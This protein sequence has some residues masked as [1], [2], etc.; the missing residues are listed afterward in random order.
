MRRDKTTQEFVLER[1][2]VLKVTDT[3]ALKGAAILSITLH[4]Y[5]HRLLTNV[6]ENQFSFGPQRV[7]EFTSAVID[8][9][10][11]LQ[12]LLTFLGHFGVQIFIFLSAY[13]LTRKHGSKPPPW[14]EFVWQR[15]RKLYPMVLALAVGWVLLAGLP[16]GITG[17]QRV[18]ENHGTSLLLTILGVSNMVPGYASPAIGPWWFIPF[19]MQ[20][21]CIWPALVRFDNRFGP[22]GL[23]LLAGACVGITYFV[24]GMLAPYHLTALRWPLGHMPEICLGI[25]AARYGFYP[26]MTGG[27][28]A[29]VVFV[30]SNFYA[31]LWL[32]SFPAALVICLSLYAAGQRRISSS[33]FL[34]YVGALAMPLFLINTI[35]RRYVLM[36]ASRDDTWIAG[37]ILGFVS[38]GASI[39]AA[40]LL[41]RA[42]AVAGARQD[43]Y[44]RGAWR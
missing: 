35:V 8:P 21:Y 29:A 2:T 18:L 14:A 11:S 7:F 12:A 20:F 34:Q 13:G 17:V 30:V 42:R 26:G 43:D 31:P 3:T 44:Q 9:R 40:A 23:V 15:L 5:F 22:T 25:A 1:K 10:Y 16:H 36:I 6:H 41:M 4:N 39:A 24:N 19:I 38:A 28:I 33:S 37:L 27:M 32:L